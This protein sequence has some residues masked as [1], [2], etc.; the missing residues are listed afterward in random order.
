M[1]LTPNKHKITPETS[2]DG[3]ASRKDECRCHPGES[4]AGGQPGCDGV[5]ARRQRLNAISGWSKTL[6]SR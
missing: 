1:I 4:V 5:T 3:N 2:S 6:R